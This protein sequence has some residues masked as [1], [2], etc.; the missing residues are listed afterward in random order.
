[1]RRGLRRLTSEVEKDPVHST[2]YG[3][4]RAKKY[5][6][7]SYLLRASFPGDGAGIRQGICSGVLESIFFAAAFSVL[8][9]I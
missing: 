7:K 9:F 1:M 6:Q 2:W 5:P 4:Q 8:V 3:R